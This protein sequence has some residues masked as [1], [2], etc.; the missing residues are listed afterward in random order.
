[1]WSIMT[2]KHAIW[3]ANLLT[4][5]SMNSSYNRGRVNLLSEQRNNPTMKCIQ[6]AN[7]KIK[8]WTQ[9]PPIV[10]KIYELFSNN[11]VD[12]NTKLIQVTTLISIQTK[13]QLRE[14]S[15]GCYREIWHVVILHKPNGLRDASYTIFYPQIQQE[16]QI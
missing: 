3:Y 11:K 10:S 5:N 4:F 2:K 6:Q 13:A 1:M 16:N 12:K 8:I 7:N 15:K 9:H 14:R